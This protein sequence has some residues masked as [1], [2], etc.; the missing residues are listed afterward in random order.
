M[1][2]TADTPK[3]LEP[4]KMCAGIR[5]QNTVMGDS[6]ETH[7]NQER[8]GNDKQE[9]MAGSRAEIAGYKKFFSTTTFNQYLLTLRGEKQIAS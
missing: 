7:R 8:T 1:G 3:K 6:R 4:I 5:D 2:A 9:N